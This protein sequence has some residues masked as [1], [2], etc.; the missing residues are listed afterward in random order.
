MTVSEVQGIVTDVESLGAQILSVLEAL[1]PAVDV[2]AVEAGTLL[3]L[4]GD[5]VTSALS[6]IS[7]AQSVVIS[8][9]SIA[10][11]APDPTPLTP[12]TS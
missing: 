3:K 11:L 6:G 8:D 9:A 2:P 10:T 7:A 12:P 5:M 4:F 1:D